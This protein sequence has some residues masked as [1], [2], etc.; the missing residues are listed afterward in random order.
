MYETITPGASLPRLPKVRA[1]PGS[2][3]A[4]YFASDRVFLMTSLKQMEVLLSGGRRKDGKGAL[5]EALGLAAAHH[6]LVAGVNLQAP[7]VRNLGADLRGEAKVLQ[8]LFASESGRLTVVADKATRIELRLTFSEA[9]PAKKAEEAIGAGKQLVLAQLAQGK[10]E[11]AREAE[12]KNL[13]GFSRWLLQRTGPFLTQLEKDIKT[14]L[15]V[16]RKDGI[17]E[18]SLK[19]KANAADLITFPGGYWLM[20]DRSAAVKPLPKPVERKGPPPAR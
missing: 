7:S 4:L 16:K 14:S 1:G 17:L 6:P 19:L 18:A 15:T 2:S 11:L 9:G 3:K 20:A 13:D 5:T 12:Q 10:K 8:P